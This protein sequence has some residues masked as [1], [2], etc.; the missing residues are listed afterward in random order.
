M[1]FDG[2]ATHYFASQNAVLDSQD[3]VDAVDLIRGKGYGLGGG[4]RIVIFAN[5]QEAKLI[6]QWRA[7]KESRSGGPVSTWDFIPSQASFPYLTDQQ[8]V[9]QL[10]PTDYNGLEILGSYG[11]TWVT[12]SN[13][14]PKNYVLVAATSGPGSENNPV[15]MRVHPLPEWQGLR[16]LP[17]NQSGY[18]L[19]DSFLT[20]GFGVG[21]SHRGSAVAIFVD[22]GSSYVA[23]PASA[24]P[25]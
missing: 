17:G 15:G 21:V 11:P 18:P 5:P 19:I 16:I 23:P 6:T 25:V 9:G 1:E 12:E 8:I 2:T 3:I 13:W 20:R 14:I 7:G 4:S 24:I 22:A 10:A